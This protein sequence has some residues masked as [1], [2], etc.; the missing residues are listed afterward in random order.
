MNKERK[1]TRDNS[2]SEPAK[3][4]LYGNQVN[5]TRDVNLLDISEYHLSKVSRRD[6]LLEV[7]FILHFHI[8]NRNFY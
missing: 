6:D 1:R 4:G 5:L 3:V 2:E 8:L 7:L